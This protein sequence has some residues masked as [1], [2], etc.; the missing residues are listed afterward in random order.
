MRRAMRS[1]SV[2]WWSIS[3]Q[4]RWLSPPPFERAERGPDQWLRLLQAE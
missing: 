3:F 1:L 2:K 4:A